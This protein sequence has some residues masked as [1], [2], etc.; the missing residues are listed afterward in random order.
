[1]SVAAP[2]PS[3]LTRYLSY[4]VATPA[5]GKQRYIK[6]PDDLLFVLGAF[7]V[8]VVLREAAMRLVFAP[9]ARRWVVDAQLA[10]SAAATDG[11]PAR[12]PTA[13]QVRR[14]QKAATRFAE[15]GWSALYYTIFWSFGVVSPCPSLRACAAASS[16]CGGGGAS[17][18]RR[19]P[20]P[21][22]G[23]R[24]SARL[25]SSS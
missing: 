21:S 10:P 16:A 22:A 12:V 13:K 7:L 6:G 14:Q 11:K 24:P 19:L 3:L 17:R 8:L 23:S 20:S 1:M 5:G 9:C 25:A 18:R 2:S 15:Q 4:P